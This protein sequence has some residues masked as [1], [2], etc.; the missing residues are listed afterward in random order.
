MSSASAQP[1]IELLLEEVVKKKASDLHLQVGLTPMLRIDGSLVPISGT[2]ILTEEVV[3]SL[4][5][6][7]LR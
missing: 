6:C 4:G 1:R 7:Y 2:D 3:E 5:V